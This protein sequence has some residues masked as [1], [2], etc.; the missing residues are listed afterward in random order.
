[1]TMIGRGKRS[2]RQDFGA[3]TIC[4]KYMTTAGQLSDDR[5]VVSSIINII[6]GTFVLL[7]RDAQR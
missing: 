3:I 7:T 4:I 1:M 2:A 5:V 6:C